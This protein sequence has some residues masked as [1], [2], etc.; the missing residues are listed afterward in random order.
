MI[1][2]GLMLIALG[3]T[4][5]I[6]L[7]SRPAGAGARASRSSAATP[8]DGYKFRPIEE[9]VVSREMGRRY[10][11]DVDDYAKCDVVI[12]GA[13]SAGLSCAYEL[14]KFPEVKVALVEQ[15]V[16]PGGGA[17]LGG[18][19]MSPMVVSKPADAFLDEIGVPY[20]EVRLRAD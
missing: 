4:S 11:K 14:S 17:W 19:L 10:S 7:N 6:A 18:Q 5:A 15:S 9:H 20:E 13:G 1:Y 2:A 3:S 12:V 16:S 8:F